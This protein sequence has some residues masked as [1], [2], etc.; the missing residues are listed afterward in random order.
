VNVERTEWDRRYETSELVW[1]AAPNRFVVEEI[2]EMRPGQALDLAA[3]EGRNAVWLAELGWQVTA[4]DFSAV[5]LAKAGKLAESRG[6]NVNR[7]TADVRDYRPEAAAYHLV[8][9]VYLHLPAAELAGVLSRAVTAL[10]PCGTLLIVGH[11]LT[12]LDEGVGGPQVPDV[13][14]TPES[15]SAALGGM[16]VRRAERV[17]RLVDTEAGQREAID[18]LVRA[19]RV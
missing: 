9:I 16:D 4:V 15:I 13:L 1:T 14:Y 7:V 2:A 3:G 8:L 19:V 12:N 5:G 6:V 18:T 11:D 10:A 17:R